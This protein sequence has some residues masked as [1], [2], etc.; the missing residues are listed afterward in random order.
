MWEQV[1]QQMGNP[2]PFHKEHDAS[3]M[4][5]DYFFLDV[6]GVLTTINA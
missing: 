3:H 6:L 5:N 1:C 4:M 2:N